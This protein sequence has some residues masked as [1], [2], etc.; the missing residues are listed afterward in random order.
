MT[1]EI[2]VYRSAHA[3]IQRHGE[4]A[5]IQAAMKADE[6]LDKGDLDGAVFRWRLTPLGRCIVWSIGSTKKTRPYLKAPRSPETGP[7]FCPSIA[8][9]SP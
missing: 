1:S 2:D 4:G 8:Q 9:G 5:V 6:M 7:F 3:L